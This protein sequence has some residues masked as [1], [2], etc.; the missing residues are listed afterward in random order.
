M[1]HWRKKKWF[2]HQSFFNLESKLSPVIMAAM[3][4]RSPTLTDYRTI[5][6]LDNSTDEQ[7]GDY[8]KCFTNCYNFKTEDEKIIPVWM[9]SENKYFVKCEI[10]AV[11]LNV[12]TDI[13][14]NPTS[15]K[16]NMRGKITFMFDEMLLIT[17][18]NY[19]K[20]PESLIAMK[21]DPEGKA[22]YLDANDQINQSSY[23]EICGTRGIPW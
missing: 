17:A 13:F 4:R 2:S 9:I 19:H 5:R 10:H 8:G 23:F 11:L 21:G 3:I 20:S 6:V 15:L 18:S 7:I 12:E 16:G 14:R 22:L 1:N